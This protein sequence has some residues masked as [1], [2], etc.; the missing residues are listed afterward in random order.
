MAQSIVDTAA[1]HNT[2]GTASIGL[3][4]GAT[5]EH[6]LDLAGLAGPILAP[7]LG[8]QGATPDDLARIFA[9]ATDLLLPSA[10]RQVLAAGPDGTA[11]ATAAQRL[12]DEVE[13]ALG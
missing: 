5:R 1:R 11:V 4:V 9:G 3:V 7:G 13:T 10:S 6:G 2:S 8:A 12:R